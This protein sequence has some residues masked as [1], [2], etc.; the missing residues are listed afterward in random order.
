MSLS[1]PEKPVCS[2]N[3]FLRLKPPPIPQR[4]AVPITASRY[5]CIEP[6]RVVA[7]QGLPAFPRAKPSGLGW[8]SV[9]AV[10]AAFLGLI[11]VFSLLPSTFQQGVFNAIGLGTGVT[12]IV[13]NVPLPVDY[14]Y[15]SSAYGPRWGRLHQGIDLA[16]KAG[17]PIYAASPGIVTHSG[18]ESGY[19][20]SVVINHGGGVQ[21]RYGHCAKVLVKTGVTVGKGQL[22]AQV[23]STGHST[24]PHLHFEVLVNGAR[25]NPAWYYA[26][27]QTPSRYSLQV[28]QVRD[29][30]N[31]LRSF[32]NQLARFLKA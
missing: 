24:G 7:P 28:R 18:W 2:E 9:N 20:Q 25:K 22:I 6:G 5:V 11:F 31:W 10:L 1:T 27:K 16:A 8:F 17:A 26:F 29:S 15:V 4:M 14:N 30:E 23:G 3:P 32:S 21:T 13:S 12:H 19:G